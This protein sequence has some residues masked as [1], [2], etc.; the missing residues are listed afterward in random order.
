MAM[1]YDPDKYKFNIV[2][3]RSATRGKLV[4]SAEPIQVLFKFQRGRN[5]LFSRI[6]SYRA[7]F[8]RVPPA[9]LL[10]GKDGKRP[11]AVTKF[12]RSSHTQRMPCVGANFTLFRELFRS[13][14]ARGEDY[15]TCPR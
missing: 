15:G 4:A 1:A 13:R 11:N 3:W 6:K 10:R 7:H 5:V 9:P 2:S 14:L 12:S 8:D